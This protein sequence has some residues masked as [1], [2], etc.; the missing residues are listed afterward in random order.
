MKVLTNLQCAPAASALAFQTSPDTRTSSRPVYGMRIQVRLRCGIPQP[1]RSIERVHLSC[2]FRPFIPSVH[3]HKS[4][5]LLWRACP[6]ES[7]VGS[8]SPV[9]DMSGTH[10][11]CSRNGPRHTY[12]AQPNKTCYHRRHRHRHHC[13]TTARVRILLVGSV[14]L[15]LVDSLCGGMVRGVCLT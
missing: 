3:E 14:P 2:R 11:Q 13:L 7:D 9:L 1:L 8:I 15:T 4:T 6:L 10:R 12:S 5:R